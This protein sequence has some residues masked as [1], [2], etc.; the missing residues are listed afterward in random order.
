MDRSAPRQASYA[1]SFDTV[2]D[3]LCQW[4]VGNR[5]G[6]GGKRGGSKSW[7]CVDCWGC[8]STYGLNV[9]EFVASFSVAASCGCGAGGYQP[10]CAGGSVLGGACL[11]GGGIGLG[12][13][14]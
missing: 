5:G 6:V 7:E 12:R 9:C 4:K 1:S 3:G 13:L 2:S 10:G 11:G 8:G 14:I